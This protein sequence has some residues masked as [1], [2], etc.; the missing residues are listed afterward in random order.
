MNKGILYAIGAYALWGILPLY[1]KAIHNV[2]A[3]QILSQRVVWSLVFLAILIS[4]RKEW[5]L[6]RSS[7]KGR[8]VI[9]V[10]AIAACL[11]GVNWLTY[12]WGVNA[13]FIVETSLG[14]FINPLVSVL[15]GVIFLGEKLR[16]LQWLPV[17]L[18]AVGVIYLTVSYGSLPWIALILAGTFGLYGLVKKTA[19]LGSLMG[20][21]L[22][23]AVLFV[24]CLVF[25]LLAEAQG[26]GAFGHQGLRTDLLL[27]LTGVVTAAPLLLF[28]SAVRLIPLTMIGILQ[29]LAPTIQLMIGVFI[30]DEPFTLERLIGFAIIWLALII[31]TTENLITWRR[32]QSARTATL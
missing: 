12:I 11:L 1:W 22:E 9:L 10:S 18:A 3:G 13:G 27:I 29:Y 5:S 7:I 23:T 17:G 31:F 30:Y 28:G 8:R 25:L 14:Y 32:A 4:L 6:F 16:P 20:L 24:P 15:L 26:S 19:R 2:P 21:T